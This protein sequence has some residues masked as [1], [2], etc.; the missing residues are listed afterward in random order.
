MIPLCIS[1]ESSDLD[2]PG[3]RQRSRRLCG[4][5]RAAS[6]IG[7]EAKD[8]SSVTEL[9]KCR[10]EVFGDLALSRCRRCVR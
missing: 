5:R 8:L 3:T 6:M 10:R 2:G 9:P 1:E 7:E 4:H